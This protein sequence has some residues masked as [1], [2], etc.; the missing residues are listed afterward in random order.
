MAKALRLM[1][2]ALVFGLFSSSMLFANDANA[3]VK[4]SYRGAADDIELGEIYGLTGVTSTTTAKEVFTEV[5]KRIRQRYYIDGYEVD[6]YGGEE[7]E[8]SEAF[9]LLKEKKGEFGG[10]SDADLLAVQNW[11][12]KNQVETVQAAGI[13]TNYHG[14]TGLEDLYIFLPKMPASEVLVIRAF[15]YAE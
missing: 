6:G 12:A 4:S 11:V 1:G 13:S 7:V 10:L 15:W 14:G 2:I 3:A 8:L 5:G 9:K